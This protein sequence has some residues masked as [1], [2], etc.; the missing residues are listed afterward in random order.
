MYFFLLDPLPTLS[1]VIRGPTGR[2][3]WTMQL[4]QFSRQK[5]VQYFMFNVYSINPFILLHEKYLHFDLLRA[6]VFQ[7]NSADVNVCPVKSALFK[8]TV[9]ELNFSIIFLTTSSHSG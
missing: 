1:A 8:M 3:V 9:E 5:N 2:Y 7:L 4:R 6:V